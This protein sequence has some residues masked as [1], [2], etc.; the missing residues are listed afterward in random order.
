[1]LDDWCIS[2]AILLI[3]MSLGF[4]A[5]LLYLSFLSV[6]DWWIMWI[7]F[8]KCCLVQSHYLY[9]WWLIVDWTFGHNVLW[10]LDRSAKIFIQYSTFKNPV[11][12]MQK[13]CSGL[14]LNEWAMMLQVDLTHS[15]LINITEVIIQKPWLFNKQRDWWLEILCQ[16]MT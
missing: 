13:F 12:K 15:N 6:Q 5:V 9:Q 11:C 10:N 8:L 16:Q 3:W 7:M 2:C 1:M 4:T 14:S